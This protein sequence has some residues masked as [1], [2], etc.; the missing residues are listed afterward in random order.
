MLIIIGLVVAGILVGRDMINDA[1]NKKT[2]KTLE[3]FRTAYYTFRTKYNAVPGD[4]VAPSIFWPNII[5][6]G[7]GNG[8][9]DVWP[10]ESALAWLELREAGL[11]KTDVIPAEPQYAR[12]IVPAQAAVGIWF[13][14]DYHRPL[15]NKYGNTISIFA[16][17]IVD[18]DAHTVLKSIDAYQIDKKIDDGYAES[19]RLYGLPDLTGGI[20]PIDGCSDSLSVPVSYHLTDSAGGACRIVYFIE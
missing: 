20:S 8:L 12:G 16:Q 9:I 7:N 18:A 13:N 2:A 15:V 6:Q 17:G 1:E 14:N 11:V 4:M 19:G 5:P 3:S 10:N